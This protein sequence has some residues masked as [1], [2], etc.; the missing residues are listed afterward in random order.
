MKIGDRV[1]SLTIVGEAEY[2]KEKRWMV[3]CDCGSTPISLT[4]GKINQKAAKSRGCKACDHGLR[5]HGRDASD[6]TYSSWVGMRSRCNTATTSRYERYG[7]RG[8]KVCARWTESFANFLED[9]GERPVGMT[10]DRKDS[11]GDY[12]PGNCKWSTALEQVENRD[13]SIKVSH[14]GVEYP[15]MA[16]FARAHSISYRKA[17]YQ[18]K[19]GKSAQEVLDLL[20][21]PAEL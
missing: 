7:G 11:D 19:S 21:R 5:K 14:A 18:L 8:I 4:T 12:E 20:K 16:A 9:M 6:P 3:Q 1:G 17:S 15:T 13:Y 2:V 10:L